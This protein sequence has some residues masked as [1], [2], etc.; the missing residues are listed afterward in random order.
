MDL[1]KYEHLDRA[2]AIPTCLGEIARDIN[3]PIASKRVGQDPICITLS[4]ID[5]STAEKR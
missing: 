1:E 3:T 4:V 5:I 2:D